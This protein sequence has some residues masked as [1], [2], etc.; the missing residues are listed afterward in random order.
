MGDIE[1]L[2]ASRG[3]TALAEDSRGGDRLSRAIERIPAKYDF[4]IRKTLW[5]IE[6]HRAGV[7]GLQF[8]EGLLHFSVLIAAILEEFSPQRIATVI[9]GDV[10]YGACCVEDYGS[11][12]IGCDLLVHYGHSCLIPAPAS[13]T[14]TLYV[15]VKIAV[16]TSDTLVRFISENFTKEHVLCIVTTV[17]FVDAVHSLRTCLQQNGYTVV[18]PQT[19]PLSRGEILGCTSPTVDSID[20]AIYFGDGDFHLEAFIMS[21]PQKAVYAYSPYTDTVT[22]G[23]YDVARIH[24][25]RRGDIA[26]IKNA[27]TVGVVVSMLGRQGNMALLGRVKAA[28][29]DAGL[30]PIVV[31]IPQV[32]PSKLARIRSVDCWVVIVCPRLVLDWRRHFEK[33]MLTPYELFVALGRTEWREIYPLEYYAADS[34]EWNPGNPKNIG[35]LR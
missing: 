8:P 11:S 29:V 1:E 18:V 17:Q 2:V 27:K 24:R 26:E 3:S 12:Q 34:G 30:T 13:Q 16:D 33:P 14:R 32:D 35:R 15:F 7:V 25:E 21:N 31:L 4:E 19:K 28:L 20:A 22:K 6:K 9:L 23:S 5:A 10:S